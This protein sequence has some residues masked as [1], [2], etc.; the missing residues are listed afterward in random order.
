MSLCH[1]NEQLFWTCLSKIL[2]LLDIKSGEKCKL[3]KLKLVFHCWVIYFFNKLTLI[4]IIIIDVLFSILY[5]LL[6]FLLFWINFYFY[7]FIL[8]LVEVLVNLFCALVVFINFL[9]FYLPLFYFN[10]SNFLTSKYFF[11][12]I[13]LPRQHF[14]FS[15]MFLR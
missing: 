11:Y 9:Y 5:M 4:C 6:Q 14:S 13:L 7:I 8:I 10:F 15:C 2:F 1:V 12:L 3:T